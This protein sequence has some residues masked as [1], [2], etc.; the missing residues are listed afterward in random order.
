MAALGIFAC[1]KVGPPTGGEVD[2][3]PPSV[4]RCAPAADETGVGLD[5]PIRITFSE[6]MDDRRTEEAIFV[7]PRT[8]AEYDWSGTDVAVRVRGGLLANRT[9][10]ITIGTEARDLRGNRLEK[11]HTIAFATG[12]QLNQG[13]LHG[14]VLGPNGQGA[15]ADVWAYDVSGMGGELGVAPPAYQTQSGRDGT[16][17]FAY[18]SPGRYRPFAFSDANRNG[19]CDEG[20]DVALPS[21]DVDLP[22]GADAPVGDLVLAAGTDLSPS[23]VRLQAID[24]QHLLLVFDRPVAVDDLAVRIAGLE[25]LMTYASPQEGSRVH[26]I[27]AP[28]TSG[29]TYDLELTLAGEKVASPEPV[30]GSHRPDRKA[31]SL[32]SQWPTGAAAEGDSIVLV[33]DEPLAEMPGDDFWAVSDTTQ[34]PTGHWRRSG[35]LGAVFVPDEALSPGQYRLCGHLRQLHDRAGLAP[36]DSL[37]RLS[38]EVLDSAGLAVVSGRVAGGGGGE[39]WVEAEG[40]STGQRVR[41]KADT[42]GVYR[43]EGLL[44]GLTHLS[45]FEDR[46]SNDR[47]DSGQRH[48]FE[49]AEPRGRLEP[50]ITVNRGDQLEDAD[51]QLR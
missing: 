8:D 3:Q 38:F 21:A 2:R 23:L 24:D 27:T 41:A 34:G 39:V 10:V 47:R 28:Q 9:Y 13:R 22:E 6:T 42:S 37:V 30:R 11:S 26:L 14:T 48:P 49:P 7:S 5:R 17:E 50:A 43:L 15:A 18:L 36:V 33:F 12:S 44:P 35:E 29:E 16:Y 45:A 46:N 40:E 51:I 19:R 32:V 31:P 1:A 25:V 4:L 20:E